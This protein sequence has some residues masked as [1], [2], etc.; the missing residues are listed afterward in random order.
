[1]TLDKLPAICGDLVQNEPRVGELG[2][3]QNLLRQSDSGPNATL[4]T[5]RNQMLIKEICEIQ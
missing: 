5:R 1:M 3:F 2:F 4:F